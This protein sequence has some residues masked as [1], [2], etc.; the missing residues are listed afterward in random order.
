MNLGTNILSNKLESNLNNRLIV[1]VNNKN[2]TNNQF[3]TVIY[4]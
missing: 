2:V 3:I 4:Y 1:H